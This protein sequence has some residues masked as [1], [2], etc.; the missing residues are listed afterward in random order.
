MH[1]PQCCV[2]FCFFKYFFIVVL[3][4]N[5]IPPDACSEFSF[6]KKGQLIVSASRPGSSLGS[7]VSN[8][9]AVSSA[10]SEQLQRWLHTTAKVRADD[11]GDVLSMTSYLTAYARLWFFTF[12]HLI[13]SNYLK[14]EQYRLITSVWALFREDGWSMWACW[15]RW[16]EV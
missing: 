3:Q 5:C 10:S 11:T 12:V 4:L 7:V 14:D 2:L 1:T 16:Q 8:G 15:G 6:S 9:T 13:N